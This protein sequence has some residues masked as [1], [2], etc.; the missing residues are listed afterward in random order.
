L[1]RKPVWSRQTGNS[2]QL[3]P[4]DGKFRHPAW[5]HPGSPHS[6]KRTLF[7]PV[8]QTTSL[9]ASTRSTA[10]KTELKPLATRPT[11]ESWGAPPFAPLGLKAALAAL[12]RKP[13]WS[14]QTGNSPQLEPA[15]GK[16][17]HPAWARPGSPH[18][19]KQTLD[20]A[21]GSNH[22]PRCCP[23]KYCAR[24]QFKAFCRLPL[25]AWCCLD[26]VVPPGAAQ[27][28]LGKPRATSKGLAWF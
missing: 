18:S 27:P 8:D 9:A 24:H 25:R 4:A 20:P 11:P 19:K 10:R 5:A 12:R 14:R 3:E 15:D 2:P 17:R 6:K 13:V 16:F 7:P 23:P 21:R 28:G 1:R 26:G 22:F